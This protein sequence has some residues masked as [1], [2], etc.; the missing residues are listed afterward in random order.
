MNQQQIKYKP[1]TGKKQVTICVG[2]RTKSDHK[3][4]R[5]DENQNATFV[6]LSNG[7]AYGLEVYLRNHYL[8]DNR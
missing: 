5:I 2:D 6:H 3:V 1:K 7:G 8:G 4:T